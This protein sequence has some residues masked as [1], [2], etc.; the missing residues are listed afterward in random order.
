MLTS[1]VCLY[2]GHPGEAAGTLTSPG[3]LEAF[4]RQQAMAQA[5]RAFTPPS[6][7]GFLPPFLSSFFCLL[8]FCFCFLPLKL[9]LLLDI[10]HL[11]LALFVEVL[12][13]R[14]E[15]CGSVRQS[16]IVAVGLRSV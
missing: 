12:T 4:K 15:K 13:P 14:T 2:Q 7:L 10:W 6:T 8:L 16:V 11:L 9:L 1:R 5:G 3:D